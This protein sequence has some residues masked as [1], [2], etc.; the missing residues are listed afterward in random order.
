MPSL[1]LNLLGLQGDPSSTKTLGHVHPE[2]ACEASAK[3][4]SRGRLSPGG[5]PLSISIEC[6]MQL[7]VSRTWSSPADLVSQGHQQE[8][9]SGEAT[10]RSKAQVHKHRAHNCPNTT[11]QSWV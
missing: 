1:Q 8:A 10:G 4:R 3:W 7:R 5:C 2:H 9:G 6:H 11:Q